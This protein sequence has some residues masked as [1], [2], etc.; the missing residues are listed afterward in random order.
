MKILGGYDMLGIT[1]A[2][3]AQRGF[4]LIEMSIVLVI[5]GLIIGGILK[6]QEIIESSRQK[7]VITQIDAVRSAVNTFA[8]KYNALPGDYGSAATRISGNLVDGDD[9][10]II[11]EVIGDLETAPADAE[12][13]DFFNHLSG[14]ELLSGTTINGATGGFG[15]GN[16]WPAVAIPAAGM[17]MMYGQHSLTG[18]TAAQRRSHWLRVHKNPTTAI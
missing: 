8:D 17:T 15:D 4:T 12:Q 1:H 7:N 11:G 9:S 16:A 5:I 18:A 2:S 6:G 13:D 3:A 14:A 10:G